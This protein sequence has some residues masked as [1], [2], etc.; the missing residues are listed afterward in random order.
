MFWQIWVKFGTKDFHVMPL[1]RFEFC[2]ILCRANRSL[3]VSV[4]EIIPVFLSFFVQFVWK[5]VGEIS[6]NLNWRLWVP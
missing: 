5:L 1:S 6:T 2:E 4:N 3:L